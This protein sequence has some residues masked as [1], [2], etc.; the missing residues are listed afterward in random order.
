MHVFCRFLC[1]AVLYYMRGCF[2][3]LGGCVVFG[4][5]VQP[6]LRKKMVPKES[7]SCMKCSSE[8][9]HYMTKCGTCN[10]RRPH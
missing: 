7:W 2:F 4:S 5:N 9:Q 10:A 6:K 3:C 1:F 8:N